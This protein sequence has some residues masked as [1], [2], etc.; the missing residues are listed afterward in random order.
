MRVKSRG[1]VYLVGAGP[2]DAGLLTLR[3]AELLRHADVVIYD[4]LVNPV[5]LKLARENAE[6][7]SRGKRTEFPQEKINE[8]MVAKAREGK[9]VVRLKGGD[10]YIFGR[11][12]E[13][14]E[15][16]AAAKIQFE[17]VPGVSSIVAVP[18]YAGIPLTHRDFCSSFTVF[19][20]HEDPEEGPAE[21]MYD[22]IAK[23]PGT[24]VALMGTA[25][26]DEWAKTLVKHGVPAETPAAIVQWGTLGKQKGTPGRIALPVSGDDVNAKGVVMKLVDELGFDPVDA[27]TLDESWRQQPGTPVYAQDFDAQGVR[28]AL[29]EAP[30]ERP[31]E[32]TGTPASPG[33]FE[34]PA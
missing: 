3:G 2:G 6:I 17:I 32:F 11:G 15:A 20:G 33:T 16:L 26:L 27:G 22:Q 28:Q 9:I 30:R 1:A 34:A 5:L 12:G 13:E 10:P 8:L 4:L 18:N 19:T 21:L 14:A 25:K 24:K 29:A 7:I 23:I 31:A